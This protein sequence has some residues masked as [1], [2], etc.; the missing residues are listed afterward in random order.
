MVMKMSEK[1]MP[2]IT[3]PY[4]I[5]CHSQTNEMTMER[6]LEILSDAAK[7]VVYT[8]VLGTPNTQKPLISQGF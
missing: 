2:I 4:I 8:I 6:K 7:Y 1:A 3:T 5:D